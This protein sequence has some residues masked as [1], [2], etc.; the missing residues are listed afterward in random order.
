MTDTTDKPQTI[1]PQELLSLITSAQAPV[2]YG[3]GISGAFLVDGTL[4]LTITARRFTPLAG[5]NH[6][7]FAV[8]A[9]LRLSAEATRMLMSLLGSQAINAFAGGV[10]IETPTSR[11]PH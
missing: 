1:G 3:D 7:D 5:E 6:S 4:A 8:T 10:A 9:Q 11:E 2:I